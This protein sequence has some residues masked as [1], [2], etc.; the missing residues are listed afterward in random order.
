MRRQSSRA[1]PDEQSARDGAIGDDLYP[2]IMSVSDDRPSCCTCQW[3]RMQR[4]AGLAGP[5]DRSAPRP[6]CR[7]L[8]IEEPE[9]RICR[10]RIS[11]VGSKRRT[12]LRGQ[13]WS[14]ARLR[15]LMLLMTA[16]TQVELFCCELVLLHCAGGQIAPR[17]FGRTWLMP[18]HGQLLRA[19]D[20]LAVMIPRGPSDVS[21]LYGP[22]Y[23]WDRQE[24]SA[25]KTRP[26]K[27]LLDQRLLCECTEGLKG[28]NAGDR[29]GRR[30]H[31]G[32]ET[33]RAGVVE[34]REDSRISGHAQ[35]SS[36]GEEDKQS[37]NTIRA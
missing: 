35:A 24:R 1:H 8:S 6:R 22:L 33:R 10:L 27:S 3:Y 5:D 37:R 32:P 7:Q 28:E 21:T 25:R 12:V 2:S 18:C 36:R 16:L 17:C 4:T 20:R 34:N 30:D 26:R 11:A 23:G 9:E 14:A 13:S 29:G 15:T 31:F 19:F